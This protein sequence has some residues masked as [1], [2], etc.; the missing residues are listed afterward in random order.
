MRR[1][2][3]ISSGII[4]TLLL[5]FACKENYTPKAT[6]YIRVDYPKK[7]YRLFES[8]APFKFEYPVYA[9][10][11]PDTSKN[12]EAFWYNLEFT[13]LS[14]TVYLSYKPVGNN[15]EEYV[16][17]SRKLAYKHSIKAES[18]DETLINDTSRNVYGIIYDLKGNTASSMQFFTTDSCKHFL[19]G[20]L[21]FNSEP[22]KDSLAPV[23]RFV[24]EDIKHL[25][26]TLEWN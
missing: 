5:S 20:S 11:V 13:D 15:L 6:G 4:L 26:N 9:K 14:G 7:E 19:R 2:L 16:S 23:I 8:N 22:N 17:D 24:R 21:Y 1:I 10:V 12:S 3:K 18:I 25:I